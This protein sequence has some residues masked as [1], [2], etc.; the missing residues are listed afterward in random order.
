VDKR[1]RRE[2]RHQQRHRLGH[3]RAAQRRVDR[4]HLRVKRVALVNDVCLLE[5]PPLVVE[6]HWWWIL[7]GRCYAFSRYTV[8]SCVLGAIFGTGTNDAY[9]EQV[10]NITELNNTR[11]TAYLLR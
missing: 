2:E 3:C 4:K 8:G 5:F 9:L 6:W 1:F 10:A 7:Y 11:S